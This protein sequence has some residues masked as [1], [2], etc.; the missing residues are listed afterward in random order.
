MQR[1]ERAKE[2]EESL[3]KE[4]KDG[5]GK[6]KRR[7]DLEK[8]ATEIGERMNQ[9]RKENKRGNNLIKD[10]VKHLE[11]S[12]IKDKKMMKNEDRKLQERS[13]ETEEALQ[14]EERTERC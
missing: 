6:G 4:L 11:E 3:V 2:M 1:E 8:E 13:E 5:G 9:D 7:E 14:K 10:I 12:F